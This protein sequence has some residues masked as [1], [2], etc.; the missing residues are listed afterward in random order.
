[1]AGCAGTMDMGMEKGGQMEENF[2]GQIRRVWALNGW[3]WRGTESVPWATREMVMPTV[4]WEH[5]RRSGGWGMSSVETHRV[6]GTWCHPSEESQREAGM[7]LYM[8]ERR[9]EPCL[10]SHGLGCTGKRAKSG[11]LRRS[12]RRWRQGQNTGHERLHGSWEGIFWFLK[13]L[14]TGNR[15]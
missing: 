3:R 11:T 8:L 5:R 10:Q 7:G 13:N 6:W 15:W 9:D 4:R 14:K 2:K 1:M 12:P